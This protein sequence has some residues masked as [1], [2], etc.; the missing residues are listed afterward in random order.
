MIDSSEI[1]QSVADYFN[2][3]IGKETILE[4]IETAHLLLNEAVS[5]PGARVPAWVNEG[6]ASHVESGRYGYT[7][8][9][10][11]G[12]APDRMPLRHMDSVPGRISDI[13]YFYRKAESVVGYLLETHGDE[14]F[15]AFLDQLD[16]GKDDDEALSEVYGFGL[17][18]LDRRWSSPPT[19]EVPDDSGGRAVPFGYWDSVLI[20]LLVLV[21][22]ALTVGNL[23]LRKLRRRAHGPEEWDGLTEEEWEGRP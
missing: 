20:A 4:L 16:G 5:S 6:F 17:D 18:G 11:G 9:F 1:L 7:R 21:V 13:R 15:R 8:G 14:R 19:Q 22:M 12:D 3:E 23:V 10:S 2:D